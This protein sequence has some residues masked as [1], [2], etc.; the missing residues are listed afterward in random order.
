MTHGKFCV[1]CFST[2]RVFET[3]W[4]SKIG[5]LFK[6]KRF[7]TISKVTVVMKQCKENTR[8]NDNVRITKNTFSM[9]LIKID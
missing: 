5:S 8:T 3:G 9:R 7:L 6:K 2:T 4:Y 1:N